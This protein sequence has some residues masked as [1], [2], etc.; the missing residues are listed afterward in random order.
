MPEFMRCKPCG[1][2]SRKDALRRVC[3][4]C[5]APLTAFEPYEDR[6][7][8]AR[9]SILN[10]DLHPILVHA[11]Q[12]FATLLPGL[13]MVAMLFPGF[14]ANEL[15]AVVCFTSLILPLSVVGAIVSGLIDGKVKFKRL[16]VPLVM[17]KMV[18]GACLLLLSIV[19][20]AIVLVGG[21]QAS[22]RPFVLVLGAASF[23]C[24]VLLGHTG[25][26]LILPILPG[27]LRR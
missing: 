2:I 20:A 22:V 14:Y 18:A 12:T 10:L 21:F 15:N 25:K 3:P 27:R 24:A 9:R 1:Y 19:N 16:G 4:A 13:V 26:K 17:L 6:V 5:G 23:L 7:S 8:A 11:P